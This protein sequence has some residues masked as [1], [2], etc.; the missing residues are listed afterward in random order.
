MIVPSGVNAG[1]SLASASRWCRA[2]T[3]SSTVT[4]TGSPLRCGTGTGVISSSNTPFLI[5]AAA[6]W[7]ERTA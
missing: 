6:S 1:L 2:R 3:P 4:S 5:A 7:C